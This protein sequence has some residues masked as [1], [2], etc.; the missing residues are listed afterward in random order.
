MSNRQ[1]VDL[2]LDHF[3][4]NENLEVMSK[5]QFELREAIYQLIS[6]LPKEDR[7]QNLPLVFQCA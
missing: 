3:K 7:P 2:M 1:L 6:A 4:T 5:F